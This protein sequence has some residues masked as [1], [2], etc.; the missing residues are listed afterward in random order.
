MT[1][2]LLNIDCMEYMATLKDNAFDL[3]VVDPPYG[4]GEDWK[5]RKNT[6]ALY[7]DGYKNKEIPSLEYFQ[8]LKRVS[9]NWI[10]WGWNYFTDHM[11]PTNYLIYWD[12]LASE[13]TSFYSQGELAGTNIK[14]PFRIVKIPWDG[15]RRGDETGIKKI[16]P[17]QKPIKLYKWILENYAE[18][19]CRILDTHLGSASSAIAAHYLDFDFV[20]CEL[21]KIHFDGAVKR[22]EKETRQIKLF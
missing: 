22:F 19:G 4:I 3:A 15:A 14:K 7:S 12:K 8:Q 13:K 18:H 2:E 6:S 1:V 20:G 10:I 16:H 5:K 21:D 11:E 17:H 9:K